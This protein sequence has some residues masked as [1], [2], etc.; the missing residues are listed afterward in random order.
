[1]R[2]LEEI[3]KTGSRDRREAEAFFAY[4]SALGH[5]WRKAVRRAARARGERVVSGVATIDEIRQVIGP[6]Y[7]Q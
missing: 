3:A 2:P 5:E 6:M 7:E 1:M 4:C